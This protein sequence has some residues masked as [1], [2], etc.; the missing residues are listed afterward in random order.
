VRRV[1]LAPFAGL[2]VWVAATAGYLLGLLGLA[3]ARGP[4]AVPAAAPDGEP[5]DMVVLVPAHDEAD[6]LAVTLRALAGQRY[7]PHRREVVV[8]ADNCSDAT[9]NV[10]RA[11]GATVWERVHD[12]RGKGQVLAW[13]LDR[14]W[15]ERPHVEAVAIVDADCLAAADLLAAFDGALRSGAAAAQARYDVANPEASPTSALRWAAFAL[16]HRVRPR[17]RAALGLSSGLFGTGM[18]FRAQLLRA[19]PW[20]SFSIAEDI[21]YHLELA[22]AGIRVTQVEDTGVVSR[23]PTTASTAR[24]QQL[25]WESG[26]VRLARR[27]ALALARAGLRQRDGNLALAGLEL[28]L[29]PHSLLAPANML[30]LGAAAT[31]R[32]RPLG[33]IGAATAAAQ[34]VYVLGGLR[35][36]GAPR[37]VY[38]AL[39]SAPRFAVAKLAIFGRIAGGRG[40][41]VWLRTDREHAPAAQP[42][43]VEARAA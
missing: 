27:H 9:A 30:C 13:A 31:A 39:A 22:R 7:P 18:A 16:K 2:Q 23:M 5:L 28:L 41:E 34:I 10:A 4:A 15:R 19:H 33:L 8:L 3:A 26:N 25:R 6:G 17:G 14:L 1:L 43:P 32:S 37:P 11:G 38:R 29:L 20:R 40:T 24:R 35:L 21:E 36:I 12:D 42:E